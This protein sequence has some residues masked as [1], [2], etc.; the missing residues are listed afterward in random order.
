MVLVIS[1]LI[2]NLKTQ[3]AKSTEFFIF[4]NHFFKFDNSLNIIYKHFRFGLIILDVTTEG[5]MSQLFYLGPSSFC[6]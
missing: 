6:I 1:L 2:R 3:V 4:F 5:T